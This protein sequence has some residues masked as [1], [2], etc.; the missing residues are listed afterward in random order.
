MGV[1]VT[2]HVCFTLKMG[3]MKLSTLTIIIFFYYF[4]FLCI[5]YRCG[6]VNSNKTVPSA[7]VSSLANHNVCSSEVSEQ[8]LLDVI[9]SEALEETASNS[10]D[11]TVL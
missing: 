1:K 10:N 6:R 8:L 2:A 11:S 4:P 5:Y 9:N 3:Y 7:Q